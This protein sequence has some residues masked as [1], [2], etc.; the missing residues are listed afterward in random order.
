MGR[1]HTIVYGS[2]GHS[3]EPSSSNRIESQW[4]MEANPTLHPIGHELEQRRGWRPP[5]PTRGLGFAAVSMF[6]I[7]LATAGTVFFL[8]PEAKRSHSPQ[9]STSEPTSTTTITNADVPS[10][11]AVA[12]TDTA[13]LPNL[14]RP[15]PP[16]DL[17]PTRTDEL[18]AN[19]PA[20]PTRAPTKSRPI[21]TAKPEGKASKGTSLPDLDRAAAA[22][23]VTPQAD[24][25]FSTPGNETPRASD[26]KI[27]EIPTD[28]EVDSNT[29]SPPVPASPDVAP[30]LQ[31]KR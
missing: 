30:Q 27:N 15:T 29:S 25:P 13:A 24:D 9:P 6:L 11:Q 5:P 8:A 10:A 16:S 22:A 26:D 12:S 19:Q 4:F 7:G 14:L 1:S 17:P 20:A 21:R 3:P 18:K 23:G 2:Q 31:L 28:N